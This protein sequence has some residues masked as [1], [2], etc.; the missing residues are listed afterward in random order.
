MADSFVTVFDANG[1]EQWTQRR[2]ARA[3]DEATAVSF[4]ADGVVYVAGRAKSAM[5]G[6]S[7]IGGWDGYVQAYSSRQSNALAPV[8]A[9]NIATRQFGST[10]DDSVQAMTVSGSLAA[11][12]P[13][14][15]LAAPSVDRKTPFA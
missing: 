14:V 7:A 2:G 11:S 13:S 15:R 6:A 8:T 12:S 5:S 4:D 10:G 3:A 1:K 9:T